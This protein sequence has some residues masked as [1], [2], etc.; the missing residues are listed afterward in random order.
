MKKCLTIALLIAI[1]ICPVFT[2]NAEVQPTS[3]HIKSGDYSYSFIDDENIEIYKYTGH[4]I[5][6]VIPSEINGF[7]VVSLSPYVFMEAHKVES[8]VVP[9]TVVSLRSD[10]GMRGPFCGACYLQTV[11]MSEN[12]KEICDYAFYGCSSLTS[13]EGIENVESIGTRAFAT[14]I[15][16][17]SI[18]FGD[19][20]ESIGEFAFWECKSLTEI[21]LPD[22]LETVGDRAFLYCDNIKSVQ[23]PKYVTQIGEAAFGCSENSSL[24][25][26]GFE[27]RGYKNTAAQKYAINNGFNFIAL[28][29]VV[30]ESTTCG[31]TNPAGANEPNTTAVKTVE[32]T[33][34]DIETITN[35]KQMILI[36]MILAVVAIVLVI[37]VFVVMLVM[38]HKR[39][40]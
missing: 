19:K 33:D 34:S 10:D 40:R 16:L 6:V 20:L 5:D 13:I 14:C 39:K 22:S 26:D 36:V 18:E 9:D 28:D 25:I 4:E 1:L 30:T 12:V 8:V 23:I 11:R 37:I 24:K 38:Y 3:K 35:L 2:A 17:E 31:E 7:N 21:N 29:S 27:I 32:K 15:K